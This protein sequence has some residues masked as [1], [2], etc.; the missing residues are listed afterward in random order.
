LWLLLFLS[1]PSYPFLVFIRASE[2][3][4]W[5][6]HRFLLP[7]FVLSLVSSL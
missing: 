7:Q 5:C 3:A 6:D 4:C 2:C 1:L